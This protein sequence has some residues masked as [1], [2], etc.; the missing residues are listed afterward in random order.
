MFWTEYSLF[1]FRGRIEPG[2]YCLFAQFPSYFIVQFP[3]THFL[4][5]NI[6]YAVYSIRH[7]SYVTPFGLVRQSRAFFLPQESTWQKMSE[8]FIFVLYTALKKWVSSKNRA[9]SLILSD[10]KAFFYFFYNLFVCFWSV[11]L[12]ACLFISPFPV[13]TPIW[14]GG[15]LLACLP[16]CLSVLYLPSAYCNF[17]ML[18]ISFPP[19]CVCFLSFLHPPP[20][21]DRS[22]YDGFLTWMGGQGLS[23]L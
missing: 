10:W 3:L 15:P 13:A 4:F 14:H 22:A 19:T 5:K 17:H 16:V 11:C 2:A 20:P 9:F 6:F 12:P 7:T 18:L 1:L 8:L 23:R 21:P